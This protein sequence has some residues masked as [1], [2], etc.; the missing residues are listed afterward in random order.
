VL[1]EVFDVLALVDAGVPLD[2]PLEPVELPVLLDPVLL[3]PALL[4][5]ELEPGVELPP[6]PPSEPLELEALP[7]LDPEFDPEL[8]AELLSLRESVR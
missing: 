1:V 4:D 5:P 7:E 3:D 6:D 2:D 8:D